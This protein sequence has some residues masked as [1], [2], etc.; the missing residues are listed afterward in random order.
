MR[1][2][3]PGKIAQPEQVNFIEPPAKL[4]DALYKR[5]LKQNYKKVTDGKDLFAQLDPAIAVEKCPYLKAMLEEMLTL[6]KAAGL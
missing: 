5:R 3:F 6:A 1:K 2:A 4:L